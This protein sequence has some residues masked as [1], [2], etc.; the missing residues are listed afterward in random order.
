[1][2]ELTRTLLGVFMVVCSG[3]DFEF[4]PVT[5]KYEENLSYFPVEKS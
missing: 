5:V 4:Q 1:M 3:V 2:Q